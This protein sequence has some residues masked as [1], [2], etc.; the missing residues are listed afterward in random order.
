MVENNWNCKCFHQ[1]E[2][3]HGD[4]LLHTI[5]WLYR[6]DFLYTNVDEMLLWID[7]ELYWLRDK[8]YLML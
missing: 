8:K 6:K 1:P 2:W 7:R 4:C 3:R 5:G